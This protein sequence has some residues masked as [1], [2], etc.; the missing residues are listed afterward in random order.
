M[1]MTNFKEGQLEISFPDSLNV[2]KFD[3]EVK[4]KPQKMKFLDFIINDKKIITLIEI[5]DP[6]DSRAFDENRQSFLNKLKGDTLI[7]EEL[8]PKCRDAYI[9]LHLM[10]MDENKTFKYFVI[11]GV[12]AYP[13]QDQA[14]LPSFKDRL[15]TKILHETDQ[16]WKRQYIKD[17]AV[18]SIDTWNKNFPNWPIKRITN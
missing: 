11:I 13:T 7:S 12:D 9:Y 1:I 3:E 17:C 10:K 15:L 5:K 18:M 2:I 14:L 4:K 8:V 6:S 16:P